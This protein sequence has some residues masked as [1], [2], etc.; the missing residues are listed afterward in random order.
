MLLPTIV[1][2]RH[3]G[4]LSHQN[5]SSTTCTEHL[6]TSWQL[7]A[8]KH[9]CWAAVKKHVHIGPSGEAQ[10]SY[11]IPP[12]TAVQTVVMADNIQRSCSLAVSTDQ[13]TV[14]RGVLLFAEQVRFFA[15]NTIKHADLQQHARDRAVL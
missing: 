8:Q 2:A 5:P 7:H 9:L 11:I 12:D 3:S 1:F 15:L 13:D 6:H 14:I 10:T 4:L